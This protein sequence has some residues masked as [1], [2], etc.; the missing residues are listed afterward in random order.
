MLIYRHWVIMAYSELS[1]LKALGKQKRQYSFFISLN[2][3][4]KRARTH[5]NFADDLQIRNWPVFYDALPVCKFWIKLMHPFKSYRSETKLEGWRPRR[6]RRRRRS[7][8]PYVSTMLRRRHKKKTI[9]WSQDS[10]IY[11][12]MGAEI[13]V[14]IRFG[15]KPNAAFSRPNTAPDERTSDTLIGYLPIFQMLPITSLCIRYDWYSFE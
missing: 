5:L 8:D 6:H 7:H 14:L 9:E 2:L 12:P 3:S 15:P 11:N 10:P 4:K 13:R 1:D